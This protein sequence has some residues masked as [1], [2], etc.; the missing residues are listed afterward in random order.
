MPIR[1]RVASEDSAALLSD[2]HEAR[3]HALAALLLA[4]NKVYTRRSPEVRRL[5]RIEHELL[6][7]SQGVSADFFTDD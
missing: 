2:L 3:K 6:K 7:L 5:E 1:K 4:E